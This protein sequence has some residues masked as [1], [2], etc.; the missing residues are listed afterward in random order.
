[1]DEY[2]MK[3]GPDQ[4]ALEIVV[5]TQYGSMSNA[6]LQC[7]E[8][9]MDKKDEVD[10]EDRLDL[11]ESGDLRYVCDVFY[12]A[13]RHKDSSYADEARALAE[14]AKILPDRILKEVEGKWGNGGHV[15]PEKVCS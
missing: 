1:M 9:F 15:T 6:Y 14:R 8:Y 12:H 5:F 2:E 10:H 11:I 13:S 3:S 4:G 7:I